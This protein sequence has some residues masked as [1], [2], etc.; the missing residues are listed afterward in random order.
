[1]ECLGGLDL[2][3]QS[4]SGLSERKEVKMDGNIGKNLSLI[5]K[6][7]FFRWLQFSLHSRKGNDSYVGGR[8]KGIGHSEDK[9]L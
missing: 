4:F 3:S 7:I 5:Q 2:N 8:E 6:D 1:M 9:G